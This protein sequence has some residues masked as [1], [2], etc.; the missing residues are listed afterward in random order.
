MTVRKEQLEEITQG[1]CLFEGDRAFTLG[2]GL[3]VSVAFLALTTRDAVATIS[4]S[5]VVPR[6]RATRAEAL[7]TNLA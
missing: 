6:S 3:S 2:S 5:Y 1:G 4:R 7:G